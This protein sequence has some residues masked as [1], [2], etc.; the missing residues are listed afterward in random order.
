MELMA[1]GVEGN[2]VDV[3]LDADERSTELMRLKPFRPWEL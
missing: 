3:L 2:I 1:W